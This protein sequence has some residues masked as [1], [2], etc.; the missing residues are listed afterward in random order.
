MILRN[1]NPPFRRLT[2]P[3]HKEVAK[4]TLKAILRQAGISVEEFKKTL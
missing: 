1:E 2:I 3:N 4:G